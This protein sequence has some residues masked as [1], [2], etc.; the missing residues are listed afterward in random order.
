MK[1]TIYNINHIINAN[2]IPMI[3]N[4]KWVNWSLNRLKSGIPLRK[5]NKIA[6]LL[7]N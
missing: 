3:D 4:S 7:T 5:V 2:A 1:A 6:E